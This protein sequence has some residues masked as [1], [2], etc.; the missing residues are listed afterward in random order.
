[1]GCVQQEG[2]NLT[3][4]VGAHVQEAYSL[5]QAGDQQMGLAVM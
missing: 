3:V 1:M 2:Y 4:A 5:V